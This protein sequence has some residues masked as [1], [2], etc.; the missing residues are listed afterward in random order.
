MEVNSSGEETVVKVSSY[1][2]FL[3]FV[4]KR[5]T[6]Y[7]KKFVDKKAIHNNK[8]AGE[9]DWGRAQT[10][11]WS[12]ET[13]WQTMAAYR[14]WNFQIY[15]IS[16]LVLLCCFLNYPFFT[17]FDYYFAYTNGIRL[18]IDMHLAP[19]LLFC[20]SP[21]ELFYR[22]CWNKD[23]CADQKS[24]SKILHQG[25]FSFWSANA[26]VYYLCPIFLVASSLDI[27]IKTS[28]LCMFPFFS[29]IRCGLSLFLYV[30]ATVMAMKHETWKIFFSYLDLERIT[31]CDLGSLFAEWEIKLEHRRNM[32][33]SVLILVPDETLL[34]LSLYRWL[35]KEFKISYSF[36]IEINNKHLAGGGQ[37][38]PTI[39]YIGSSSGARPKKVTKAGSPCNT[40]V[41]SLWVRSLPVLWAQSIRSAYEVCW[42]MLYVIRTNLPIHSHTWSRS[43]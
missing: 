23:G 10:V 25:D 43:Q 6:F 32:L 37:T 36:A 31:I 41:R 14:R 4:I 30:R 3:S 2:T 40:R 15:T 39:L 33:G 26:L 22:A 19:F 9:V 11:P 13:L 38:T 1:R 18:Y 35:R 8:A 24:C 20:C 29:I 27:L 7:I 5:K 28:Q 21:S 17:Q 16:W 12:L 34:P 42:F